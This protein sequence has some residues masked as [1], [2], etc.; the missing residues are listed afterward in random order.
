MWSFILIM[1]Y[2]SRIFGLRHFRCEDNLKEIMCPKSFSGVKFALGALFH[3]Y[4][5]WDLPI[6]VTTV[7]HE[8]LY[9]ESYTA[10]VK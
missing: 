5:G 6:I 1:A 3:T 10:G 9:P 2:V 8:I 7:I 4:N